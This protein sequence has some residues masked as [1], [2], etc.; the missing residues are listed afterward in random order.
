MA[1]MNKLELIRM[2]IA[3]TQM[4]ISE[5]EAVMDVLDPVAAVVAEGL[6]AEKKKELHKLEMEEMLDMY[7]NDWLSR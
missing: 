7:G 5:I 1:K 6:I 4:A 2:V 3:N